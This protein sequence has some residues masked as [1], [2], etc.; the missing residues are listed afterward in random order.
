VRKHNADENMV[1][2]RHLP[3]QHSK[4]HEKTVQKYWTEGSSKKPGW[5]NGNNRVE[6]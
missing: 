1:L 6:F 4:P 3:H 2:I 5:D